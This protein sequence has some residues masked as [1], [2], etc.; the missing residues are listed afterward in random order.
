MRAQDLRPAAMTLL[1]QMYAIEPKQRST[2][3][4]VGR[5]QGSVA[6][7]QLQSRWRAVWWVSSLTFAPP[8]P[9]VRNG[10]PDSSSVPVV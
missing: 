6:S 10:P 7:D 1:A 2:R 9:H 5:S 4:S 3:V 8:S